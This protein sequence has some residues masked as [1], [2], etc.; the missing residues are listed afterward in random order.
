V[1]IHEKSVGLQWQDQHQLMQHQR[2]L[3]L[4]LLHM[5]HNMQLQTPASWMPPPHNN[6]ESAVDLTL[7]PSSKDAVEDMH[8][9]ST[10]SSS[11]S[12]A[13]PLTLAHGQK[14]QANCQA[15]HKRDEVASK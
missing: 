4:Q 13:K 9:D 1:R 3:Q 2:L 12:P 5:R 11:P 6:N 7:L 14:L 10:T 15:Q 8:P